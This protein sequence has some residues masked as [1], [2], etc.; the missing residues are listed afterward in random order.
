MFSNVTRVVGWLNSLLNHLTYKADSIKL[1]LG[2]GYDDFE[3][4]DRQELF[5]LKANTE[6][7]KFL[8]VVYEVNASE[9]VR[10]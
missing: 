1:E 10:P 8:I 2:L 7:R 5:S 6:G 9:A 3:V 4:V